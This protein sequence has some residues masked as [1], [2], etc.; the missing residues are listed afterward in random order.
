LSFL[1]RQKERKSSSETK[2]RNDHVLR[3]ALIA[4]LGLFS[5]VVMVR[6]NSSF[7][8]SRPLKAQCILSG[9]ALQGLAN[10]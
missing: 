4:L 1:F 9:K 7:R 10:H 2:T 5:K 6:S 8:Q 3:N